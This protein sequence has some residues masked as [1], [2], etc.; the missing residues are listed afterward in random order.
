MPGFWKE[1]GQWVIDVIKVTK[2]PSY[3]VMSLFLLG[4]GLS[5]LFDN[6]WL[7]LYEWI[8]ENGTLRD[9][10]DLELT[11][12]LPEL[13]IGGC[14]IFLGIL[15]FSI[16]EYIKLKATLG[17]EVIGSV[18]RN[19]T[20]DQTSMIQFFQSSN[21]KSGQFLDASQRQQLFESSSQPANTFDALRL[22]SIAQW[23][24]R[25]D[26]IHNQF[27]KLHVMIDQGRDNPDGQFIKIT[28][29]YD[30]LKSLIEDTPFKDTLAFAILGRPG[31]GKSTLLQHLEYEVS[32]AGLQSTRKS[33]KKKDLEQ[34]LLPFFVRLNQYPMPNEGQSPIDP[35]VWLESVWKE[36]SGNVKPLKTVLAE[37]PILF[38]LDALNEM[39]WSTLKEYEGLVVLWRNFLGQLQRDYRHCRVVFSCR[40]LNYS[41]DLSTAGLKVPQIQFADMNPSQIDNYMV[42]KLGDELGQSV[43]KRLQHLPE[44]N[45]IKTP[46]YLNL[47]IKYFKATQ[48]INI[49]P[50]VLIAS[51][52]WM[53]IENELNKDRPFPLLVDDQYLTE[54]DRQRVHQQAWLKVPHQLPKRGAFIP[55]VI[56][57]A[58]VMQQ[59]CSGR[60]SHQINFKNSDLLKSLKALNIDDSV[61]ESVLSIAS[62]LEILVV[63]RVLE[64]SQFSHQILQ[65]YF[66]A[67]EFINTNDFSDLI[68][69]VFSNEMDQSIEEVIKGLAVA[70]PLPPPPFHGWEQTALHGVSMVDNPNG[71][72]R[73]LKSQDLILA[74]QCAIRRKLE[75]DDTLLN[76]LRE[77]LL[78]QMQNSEVDLRVRI[79]SGKTL[80]NLGD[81][82]FSLQSCSHGGKPFIAPKMVKIR[83]GVY[84]IG[85]EH[86]EE[87]EKPVHDIE[88]E[89]FEIGQYL[90]TNA[91]WA[92]FINDGG[93]EDTRWWQFSDRALKWQ[94]GKLED[95]ENLK[96]YKCRYEEFKL[97]FNSTKKHYQHTDSGVLWWEEWL[98][99]P[100]DEFIIM[101]KEKFKAQTFREPT[102]WFNPRFNNPSQPVV[103]VSW[104]EALA[105]CQW[106]NF[107]C[108]MKNQRFSLPSEAQWQAATE[109]SGGKVSSE[110]PW[111]EMFEYLLANTDKSHI[112]ATT[113]VGL[114]LKGSTLCTTNRNA[115]LFDMVGNTREWTSSR[116][117]NYPI[118]LNDGRDNLKYIDLEYRVLTGGSWY[119]LP[120]HC[121]LPFRHTEFPSYRSNF[122]GFRLM[123]SRPYPNEH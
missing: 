65:E 86:G 9:I 59:G 79:E 102:E 33:A 18:V 2:R 21:F 109:S 106:L 117:Q 108:N 89:G 24:L 41:K 26:Q 91:E 85:S 115:P 51:M 25:D 113:P 105:Y 30:H 84:S 52:I 56:A 101:L 1:F 66:S 83:G 99:K 45:E 107:K 60:E 12:D 55:T 8:F 116:F 5:V 29:E 96:W 88:L 53:A 50:S 111:G 49:N 71:W 31:C 82:R 72:I 123:L 7:K 14:F 81:P 58:W 94:Q 27:T 35:M 13:W 20:E 76:E 46:F 40:S 22:K 17:N 78:T 98:R 122:I 43:S 110:Y 119:D 120:H 39:P 68:A 47:A 3:V 112:C 54:H 57:I 95:T 36:K 93:Y 23:L 61:A 77:S 11:K 32:L 19:D 63:D 67:H 121:R 4:I 69:L 118:E 80:G 16:F 92:C 114:Y 62:H 87:K 74:A 34:P 10:L 70:E 64:S 42:N 38:L 15:I 28:E 103:G 75:I 37:H 100:Y 44:F 97:D 73:S 104:Y 6:V 90:V 48:D